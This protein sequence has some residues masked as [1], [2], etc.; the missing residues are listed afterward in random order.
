M[1]DQDPKMKSAGLPESVGKPD[2]MTPA[3]VDE[4]RITHGFLGHAKTA[5]IAVPWMF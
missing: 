1:M 4:D 2:S 3:S 5:P